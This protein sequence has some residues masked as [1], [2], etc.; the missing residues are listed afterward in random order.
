MLSFTLPIAGLTFRHYQGEQDLL[1]MLEVFRSSRIAGQDLDHDD[2]VLESLED[3]TNKY[4]HLT[5]CDPYQ[6]VLIAEVNDQMV[7]YGRVNWRQIE[8]SGNRIYYLV[9]YIRPEWCGQ[10]L[11]KSFLYNNQER[12]RQIIRQHDD[13]ASSSEASFSGVRLFEAQAMDFQPELACLLEEDGFQA[14]RWGAKMTCSNLQNIPDM[15]MPAG[16]EVRPAKPE[17]YRQIWDALLDAFHDDPGYSQPTE[18]D[19]ASWQ[20]SAQFQPDL[21]QVA[22]EGNQVTGMV[23]NYITHNLA[24]VETNPAAAKSSIAWTEDI[25]VRRPWRRRG[26]ARAL[27]ARSMRMFHAMGFTETSLG[28]DL[29]NSDSTHQF[30]ESMGYQIFR[31]ST[32][33]RKPVDF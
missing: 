13:E 17:H 4:R 7:A 11:E 8:A 28:V 12:L 1:A 29:N 9:W 30:Y 22:W 3:I 26:L 32:I 33:Y 6:D 18:D 24:A 20:Q 25:C 2:T 5:N 23:L 14:V 27:L 31:L 15:P 10:G 19:Y 21:W 16:L